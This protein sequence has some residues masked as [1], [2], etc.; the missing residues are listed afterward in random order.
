MKNIKEGKLLYHLTKLSNL[1]SIL[2]F[3]LVSRRTLE[4]SCTTFADIADPEIMRKRKEFNLDSYIPFHFH[5]YS[6]FD[7]AVKK[8]H[9]EEFIYICISRKFAKNNGFLILPK[10]PLSAD[11]VQ[12]LDY[13][14]GLT[15]IDW[16]AME[17]SST[18]SEYNKNVRM[19]E[20]LT[21]KKIYINDFFSI[22]VKDE[23]TKKIINSKLKNRTG[24]KPYI[25]IQPWLS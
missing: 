10:H 18:E 9:E 17:S 11:E 2:E 6:S 5:P 20:C 23:E 15:N 7:V 4:E 16:D 25:D 14:T 19:A 1:D 12:L 24:K 13:D 21:D 22:A 3:G 8:S